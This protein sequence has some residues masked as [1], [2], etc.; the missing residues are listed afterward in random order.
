[1]KFKCVSVNMLATKHKNCDFLNCVQKDGGAT[2]LI[3]FLITYC[4]KYS[5]KS[6]SKAADWS[7]QP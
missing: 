6:S 4:I 1:M 7:F 3:I 2:H 5:Y